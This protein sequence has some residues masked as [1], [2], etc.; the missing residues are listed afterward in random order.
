MEYCDKKSIENDFN[1][2]FESIESIL[3]T[4]KS[5]KN[6]DEE[7]DILCCTLTIEDILDRLTNVYNNL[8]DSVNLN[9]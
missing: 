4:M 9:Y 8:N 6:E 5:I 3:D 7:S 2:A 1:N